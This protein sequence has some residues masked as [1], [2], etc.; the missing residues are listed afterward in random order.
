ML[1]D[2]FDAGEDPGGAFAPLGFIE[3]DDQDE[4]ADPY[5][6]GSMPRTSF[7]HLDPELARRV[8]NEVQPEGRSVTGFA[9]NLF[10]DVKRFAG[11]F[12]TLVGAGLR[13]LPDIPRDIAKGIM[14]PVN[15][16][17]GAANIAS[18][19]ASGYAESY[20]PRG[21]EGV[22]GMVAR[23]LYEQPF[24]TLMDISAV[25][26]G[27]AGVARLGTKA[28]LLSGVP[29]TLETAATVG[30]NIDPLNLAT[31]IVKPIAK[32]AVPDTVARFISARA[33]ADA[34]SDLKA[35]WRLTDKQFNYALH[36]P[37]TG[38]FSQLN[39]AEKN[40]LFAYGEGRFQLLPDA[41]EQI[42]S[43][44]GAP[45]RKAV[46]DD[47]LQK[48]D[49]IRNE[50]DRTLGRLP[51][52]IAE[53][54][55]ATMTKALEKQ[56]L[57]PTLPEHQAWLEAQAADAA[58]EATEQ[59]RL[60][61]TVSM[62]TVLDEAQ[63]ADW[64]KRIE[65]EVI[66]GR[67][68]DAA[69]A[70][71]MIP[72]PVKATPAEAMELMG[73]GGGTI[74]HHSM[75]ALTRDQS[76]VGNILSKWREASVW[77]DNEGEL[78]KQGLLDTYD[79]ERA[80]WAAHAQ[81]S[82][83]NT[84]PV[85]AGR[86]VEELGKDGLAHEMPKGYKSVADPDI[87]GGTHQLISP[88]YLHLQD[89]MRGNYRNFLSRVLEVGEDAAVGEMNIPE[90]TESFM[91]GQSSMF[92]LKPELAGKVYKI[93][94]GAADEFAKYEKSLKPNP[95][96]VAQLSDKLLGPWHFSNLRLAGTKLSND[97]IGDTIF[98]ALQGVHPF[99]VDG[100]DALV[101]AGRAMRGRYGDTSAMNERLAKIYDLPGVAQGA[102]NV[103]LEGEYGIG[104]NLGWFGDWLNNSTNPLL[105]G[106]GKWG[107]WSAWLNEHI[108]DYWRAASTV[109]EL[110]K[111]APEAMK[112]MAFSH[113]AMEH[114]ANYV[115]ELGAAGA[116]ALTRDDYMHA[117]KAVDHY[118]PNYDRATATD[119]LVLRHFL[120][121][122]KFYKHAANLLL[123]APFD[124]P[125]KGQLARELGKR[126]QNDVKETLESYGFDWN[127]MVRDD[128]RTG[129]PVDVSYGPDGSPTVMML[130]SQGPNPFSF[131]SGQDIGEAGLGALHP[132]VKIA[133]EQ[134][135]GVNL[136]T[137]RKF[138]GPYSDAAGREVDQVTGEVVDK[139]TR[140]PLIEHFLKQ[141]RLYNTARE[142]VAQGRVPTDTATL[143]DMIQ[144]EPNAWQLDERG[145]ARRKPL[146]YGPATALIRQFGLTP[147]AL[148]APTKR[149]ISGRRAEMAT[150]FNDVFQRN[151]ELQQTMVELMQRYAQEMQAEEPKVPIQPRLF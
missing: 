41:V 150:L 56:G 148:Q 36:D 30:R 122:H 34:T 85:V 10:R 6:I 50:W 93:P 126:A 13:E 18:D 11:D 121:Y 145:F 35:G 40:T 124:H 92:K 82:R 151:P 86:L 105:R 141:F 46:M 103:L 136:F 8:L 31:S 132:I 143:L 69:E 17:L 115:D 131:L 91:R 54:R 108:D 102:G 123:K 89:L 4:Y 75:E 70:A 74:F 98:G 134:A 146:P 43:R 15:T 52:Q 28:G 81:L 25:A 138:L 58:Q 135:L 114:F 62:R 139:K 94:K 100:I 29:G 117:R 107:A 48:Y 38:V 33:A 37:E 140:P 78:F 68:S 53:Q 84:L 16:A 2:L 95:N 111:T 71:K 14:H 66:E 137:G 125:V 88:G 72:R 101:T 99:S 32:A 79:L 55:L 109:Y 129:V 23:K 60:R 51:E 44:S 26:Q 128:L 12:Q 76:T 112:G 21:E 96:I 97:A 24:S 39:E 113:G 87:T 106:V 83:G 3:P 77:K 61:S 5:A 142:F 57:D 27:P 20:T 22:T 65:S 49:V 144:G 19:V 42:P 119:R 133:L 64:Q 116:G 9:G 7:K 45:L 73:P 110:K 130:N 90:L 149:Q 127:T 104:K 118:F 120:P 80:M 47:A 63:M 147:Q 59:Q 1:D 67:A